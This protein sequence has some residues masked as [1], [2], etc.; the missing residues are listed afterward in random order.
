MK[1]TYIRISTDD[2]KKIKKIAENRNWP[3]SIVLR[4]LLKRGLKE[5]SG[6]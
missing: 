5:V 2:Y 6:E 1:R 3:V 4:D